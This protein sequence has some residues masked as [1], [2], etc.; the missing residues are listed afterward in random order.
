MKKFTPILLALASIAVLSFKQSNSSE[1]SDDVLSKNDI[2]ILEII[3]NKRKLRNSN[4]NKTTVV[5]HNEEEALRFL[6]K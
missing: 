5:L 6:N 2:E 3:Q 1:K 4:E